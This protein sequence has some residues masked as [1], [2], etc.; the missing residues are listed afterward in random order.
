VASEFPL[1]SRSDTITPETE[2]C[3][4]C[5]RSSRVATT[6]A[7]ASAYPHHLRIRNIERVSDDSQAVFS[8]LFD[9]EAP[10]IHMYRMYEVFEHCPE[11]APLGSRRMNFQEFE[12]KPDKLKESVQPPCRPGAEHL[13]GWT[14]TTYFA[15][16]PEYVPYLW[17]LFEARGGARQMCNA[18]LESILELAKGRPVVN[19][20]GLSSA[21]IFEDSAPVVVMRGRQVVV[22]GA[23]II[24]GSN[25]LPVAYNYTPLPN[26]FPRADGNAEYV[27]FFP[28]SD[29]WILGQTREPGV[30]D[31]GG[32]W[33]GD[34]VGG[35]EIDIGGQAIPAPIV[36][37][38]E[39]I[40]ERWVNHDLSGKRLIG[41]E[42]YRYYRD[43]QGQ[44]VRLEYQF[45][46]GTPFIHNYGH[47]GSGITMSWGCA[48]DVA[49]LYMKQIGAK[50]PAAGH[51]APGADLDR[52]VQRL[53]AEGQDH[54]AQCES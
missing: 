20:L 42:G 39:K 38:N 49:R 32:R 2:I 4:R 27:H 12:G 40:L 31:A 8:F 23:P 13:W 52:L 43:P 28:R 25:G 6:Y 21:E 51:V 9:N 46:E 34:A 54:F 48:I 29:G 50:H 17:S 47:G 10:G 16:M 45:F 26:I 44:G 30:L 22:P 24:T 36:E 53:I 37:L 7:M 3:W 19:C 14:F 15:D 33:Q 1:Q 41:R 11:K 35:R 18:A 5:W